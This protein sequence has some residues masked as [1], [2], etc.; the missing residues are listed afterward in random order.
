MQNPETNPIAAQTPPPR[1]FHYKGVGIRFLAILVDW[2]IFG[3]ILGLLAA[4]AG[5]TEGGCDSNIYAGATITI[6][7]KE[8]FYGLCGYPAAFYMFGGLAY[9]VLM[10]WFWGGTVGKLAV[11][12]RV[13]TTGGQPIGLRESLVRNILRIVDAIP[14]CIPYLLG[15]VLVWASPDRQRLGDRAARTVVISR[16]D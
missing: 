8:T 3:V 2:I 7:G 5:T 13:R 14:Y 6:N 11:G 12:I 4:A 10:E 16:N 1:S 15:A 9:Y